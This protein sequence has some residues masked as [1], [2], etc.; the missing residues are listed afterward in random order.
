MVI[1]G[2]PFSD[3]PLM[4]LK[5]SRGGSETSDGTSGG[6]GKKPDSGYIYLEGSADA[7]AMGAVG[8]FGA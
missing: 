3:T 1:L 7:S 8:A 6:A 5:V 2:E 4:I